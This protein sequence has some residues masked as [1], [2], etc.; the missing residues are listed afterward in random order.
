M[1]WPWSPV[2]SNV[3]VAPMNRL[4]VFSILIMLFP[5]RVSAADKAIG[6]YVSSAKNIC[7]GGRPDS[8]G[9]S[10]GTECLAQRNELVIRKIADRYSVELSFVFSNGHTCEFA[11]AGVL[12]G[13][14]LVVVDPDY[15]DCPL[16]LSFQGSALH[17]TQAE[18][19]RSFF[20]GARGSINGAS[21]HKVA[22]R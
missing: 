14:E 13:N 18:Q 15:Q 2:A 19:C 21:L 5:L 22:G 7:F 17:L 1:A 6:K 9:R 4:I 11:G 8:S 20:C 16:A 12:N 3:M 10:T